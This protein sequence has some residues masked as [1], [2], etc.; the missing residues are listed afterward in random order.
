VWDQEYVSVEGGELCGDSPTDGVF[1]N[2]GSPPPATSAASIS[3]SEA[4][5]KPL[6]GVAFALGTAITAGF[7]FLMFSATPLCTL[8]WPALLVAVVCGVMA[9]ACE[10][11]S[12]RAPLAVSVS[13]AKKLDDGPVYGGW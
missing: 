8:I 12:S 9:A 13:D 10:A 1:L 6:P 2:E 7:L 5:F 11:Y 4:F 3:F